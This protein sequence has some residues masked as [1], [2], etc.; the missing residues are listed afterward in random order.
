LLCRCYARVVS[1]LTFTGPGSIRESVPS[2]SFPTQTTPSTSAR[3]EG[4][5]PTGPYRRPRSCRGLFP[6]WCRPGCSRPTRRPRSPPTTPARF[7]ADR[8]RH[9]VGRWVDPQHSIGPC[10]PYPHAAEPCRDSARIQPEVRCRT[11][12]RYGPGQVWAPRFSC[13]LV[14]PGMM[15]R[16]PLARR[17][18]YPTRPRGS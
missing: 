14:R 15:I 2:A 13:S 12:R 16:G 6:K 11:H 17:R 9:L 5:S 18:D 4:P 3:P 7:H 8:S 1:G 10:Q